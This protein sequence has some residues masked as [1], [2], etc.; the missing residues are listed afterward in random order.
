MAQ[1]DNL[2]DKIKRRYDK[3]AKEYNIF[4]EEEAASWNGSFGLLS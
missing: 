3:I 1:I 2:L 4:L